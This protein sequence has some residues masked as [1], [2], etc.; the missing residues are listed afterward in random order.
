MTQHDRQVI[1]I[2]EM[3]ALFCMLATVGSAYHGKFVAAGGYL[4][5]CLA[6]LYEKKICRWLRRRR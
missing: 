6:I 2:K 1:V 4:V 3:V 5:I